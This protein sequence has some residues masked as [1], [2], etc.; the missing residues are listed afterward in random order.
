MAPPL[1]GLRRICLALPEAVEKETWEIPTFRL[2]QT[3]DWD[4]VAALIRRS[5]RMTAPKR[6]AMLVPDPE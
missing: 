3:T 1:T 5:Y 6:M 2:D 4:E